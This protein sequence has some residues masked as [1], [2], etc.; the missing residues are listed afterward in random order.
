MAVRR[1]KYIY[2][3][4]KSPIEK[5]CKCLTCKNYSR[6]YLRHLLKLNEPI[7]KRYVSIHNLYF[8]KELMKRTRKHI[9]AGTFEK[10]KNEIIKLYRKDGSRTKNIGVNVRQ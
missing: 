2:A 5:G 3:H 6:A 10:F 4:D 8:M 7:G 9:R 1:K